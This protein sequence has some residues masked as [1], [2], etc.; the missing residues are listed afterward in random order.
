M[1]A[2]VVVGSGHAGISAAQ[3]LVAR[4][5]RVIVVDVGERLDPGRRDIVDRLALREPAD[6]DEADIATVTENPTVHDAK[7]MR[8]A[9]GSSYPYALDR[10]TAP[11]DRD[12]N[13]PAPSF[14]RGGF[15]T[16]WGAAMLPA[17][18][19]DLTGW[20]VTRQ[21][22]APY[23][24]D[25]L[26]ELPFAAIEDRLA[27]KFPL[28]GDP[29]APLRLPDGGHRL[30]ER[31]DRSRSIRKRDDV[32]YGQTR[33]AVEADGGDERPGCIYCGR[34]LS[35]CVYGSIHS[36]EQDL[37]R[38]VR[39][40][41]VEYRPGLV[42]REIT[43]SGGRV[44]I[45]C[46]RTD[47]GYEELD[48]D[49]VFLAAGAINSARIVMESRQMFDRAIPM[50]ATQGFAL[51]MFT[52]WRSQFEWPNS[53]TLAS[54]FFEFKVPGLSDHW[55]H[56]QINPAN[57]IVMARLNFDP[58][59]RNWRD[60]I[61]R[62]GFDRLL[63]AL[64]GFHSDHAG[65][66]ELVLREAVGDSPPTL[67]IVT[68]PNP[69]F[70]RVANRVGHHLLKL[71]APVGVLPA[72][73]MLWAMGHEKKPAGWHFGGSLPMRQSPA[74]DTETDELGRPK[75]WSHVHVVD[76]SVFPSIP[77]T[78]VALTAMANARRIVDQAVTAAD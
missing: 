8:L 24:R 52:M 72:V 40:G 46:M 6:W 74:A 54:V 57:E 65:S 42:V 20:P 29:G 10:P 12:E 70:R 13:G 61:L 38:L 41:K 1:V 39:S 32:V 28:Y 25:V 69:E 7:P 21:A 47:G 17:D 35:G 45:R 51:P 59:R 44:K 68:R 4:G 19:C 55:V 56:T 18:D 71:L 26:A 53:N 23:Y 33:L 77:S 64:C 60:R 14:A 34:C 49:R 3:A 76:S 48:A 66:Y 67:E 9:F 75:G 62:H 73:P 50:L 2:T 22:L 63:V 78:T 27:E 31:L 16:V 37:D 43:E 5:L 36:T 30:L 11:L 15:S 58:K